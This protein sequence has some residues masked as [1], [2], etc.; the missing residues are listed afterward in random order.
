MLY[1]KSRLK[2]SS[3]KNIKFLYLN[4]TLDGG[5][6]HKIFEYP[7]TEKREVET[8]GKRLKTISVDGI[9]SI[10][11][12]NSNRDKLENA[13]NDGEAGTLSLPFDK[14]FYGIITDYKFST[15]ID[16]VGSVKV[17]FTFVELSKEDKLNKV[18][19]GLIANLKSKILVSY[20]EDFD[21]AWQ[22]VKN[23]KEKFDSATDTLN[24]IAE[25]I[26]NVASKVA[27][28]GDS[29]GDFS[30]A[31][32][33]II[34]SSAQLVRSPKLLIGNIKIAFDNLSSSFLSDNQLFKA[35][36]E[37]FSIDVKDRI[38]TG[39]SAFSQTIRSNQQLLNQS[40][41]LNALLTSYEASV[42]QSYNNNIEIQNTL[43]DLEN[44]FNNI[45]LTLI[46]DR[47]IIDNL[48]EARY[49]VVDYLNNL[50]LSTPNIIEYNVIGYKPLV[51]IL[52]DLYGVDYQDRKQDIINLNNFSNVDNIT[53]LIKIVYE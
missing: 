52:F 39:N 42:N 23:A 18:G 2:A 6:K 40:V 49:N 3:Y 14:T 44:G 50:T 15:G 35:C 28:A 45:N 30:T 47:T 31:I 29:L 9:I 36:K 32:N 43:A 26:S 13:F 20:E 22:N 4:S 7:R 34:N 8:Y 48:Q 25:T 27:G 16:Q 19:K 17:N 21:K 24:D 51:N 11:K 12:N 53:G 10:H 38:Q 37:L 33:Q 46:N 5:I 41:R 1:N